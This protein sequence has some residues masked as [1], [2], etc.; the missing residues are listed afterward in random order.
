[1]PKSLGK[2]QAVAAKLAANNLL[3][4]ILLLG[5]GVVLS[6]CLRH[7]F[8]WDFANYH[9]Y[10]AFA[11][12][13]D[14]LNYD[15]V[16]ASINTFF[17]PLIDLPL[18]FFIQWFN[19]TPMII[20]AL[21]GIWAGLLLFV[22]YKIS[23][24]F[25][26]AKNLNGLGWIVLIMLIAVSSQATLFQIGSSTNE[27][28]T[29]FMILW[30]LYILLKMIKFPDT[31]NLWKFLTAGLIM[32]AALGLKQTVVVYCIS[33][34]LMLICCFPYF[35]K[36]YKSIIIFALGGLAGF[37]VVNGWWMWKMW[38]LYDNPVFPFL[39]GVFKSEYFDGFNYRDE[40]FLPNLKMSLI[41]PYLWYFSSYGI[42]EVS[43]EDV[44]L[45]LV[46]TILWGGLI[47]C[48]WQRNIKEKYQKH[49]LESALYFYVF[50]SFILWLL[51][52]SI[53]RY[54]VVIEI[55]GAIFL[56]MA[57]KF[58][59]QKNKIIFV[60][61]GASF[62]ILGWIISQNVQDWQD[63]R[64]NDKFVYVEP[65]D[66]PKNTLLKLY[67]FPTAFVVPELAKNNQFRAIGYAHYNCRY[68]KGSDFVER[69]KFREIRDEIVKK[70]DGP[71]V[72]VYDDGI[73]SNLDDMK[74]YEDMQMRCKKFQEAGK[75]PAS[76]DCDAGRCDTWKALKSV[77]WYELDEDEYFCRPL[78]NNLRNTLKICVPQELKTQILGE[79]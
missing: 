34:G 67:N 50:I 48:L 28:P 1:M 11:F 15:I 33:A 32:G 14:R 77:L 3:I 18:Y 21:Q 7:E 68:M 43:Y 8:Q 52:F 60:I 29:A 73:G 58:F 46:Y 69:G 25:F 44:R 74:A 70:H 40:R 4:F 65:I 45:T 61:C 5:C 56:V 27:I 37:L 64:E 75:I 35:K 13:H 57:F 76:W 62:V 49:H 39:N 71:V 41:Y 51:L 53:L 30:G 19:D 20:F 79:E 10:N 6:V 72:I 2:F 78:K 16:P 54:A 23:S 59:M 47:Y 12:L 31:Q 38:V 22:L 42:S 36:P 17:N 26:N 63:L 66:F 55:L 24:L 9:Y